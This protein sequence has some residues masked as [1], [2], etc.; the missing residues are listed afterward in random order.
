MDLSSS[1]IE[2]NYKSF[3]IKNMQL[4]LLIYII[5]VKGLL[6]VVSPTSCGKCGVPGEV[7]VAVVF[8]EVLLKFAGLEISVKFFLDIK[9]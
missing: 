8:V 3:G 1:C 5:L 9:Q 4:N 2:N 6:S 7:T